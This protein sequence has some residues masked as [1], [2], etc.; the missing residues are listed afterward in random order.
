MG[1]NSIAK[2]ADFQAL[3]DST[4]A[5]RVVLPKLGKAVLLRRP[6]PMWF[7]F[8]A[9][10]PATLAVRLQDGVGSLNTVEDFQALVHWAVPLLSHV[11]VEP[12]LSLDPGAD[13][14]SPDLLAV[15]DAS[16]VIRWAVGEIEVS[17]NGGQGSVNDLR[18]FRGEPEPAA[19]SAGGRDLGMP[20][21]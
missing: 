17:G 19:A 6:T 18:P 2:P 11:F 14:I 10:L 12:R 20:A 8:R 1:E 4:P 13:E 5:E 16:F 21:K 9:Q 3:R 15:E 7:L